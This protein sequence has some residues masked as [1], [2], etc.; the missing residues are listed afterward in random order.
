MSTCLA[1]G[2]AQ[3]IAQDDPRHYLQIKPAATRFH[4]V[5]RN[6]RCLSQSAFDKANTISFILPG[7]GRVV[8][9]RFVI[10]L[11]PISAIVPVTLKLPSVGIR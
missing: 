11:F 3:K 8:C 9:G 7:A 2:A 5:L 6:L 10:L 4:A 1:R